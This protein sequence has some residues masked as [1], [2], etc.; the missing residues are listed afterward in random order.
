MSERVG[1]SYL[2]FLSFFYF[3][4]FLLQLTCFHQV[5]GCLQ[6]HAFGNKD[7]PLD[8][9]LCFSELRLC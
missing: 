9:L 2:L 3:F 5:C 1:D 7:F 8:V 6:I 4:L